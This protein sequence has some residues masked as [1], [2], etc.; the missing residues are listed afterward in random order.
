M[1]IKRPRVLLSGGLCKIVDEL[2]RDE[3]LRDFVL[4]YIPDVRQVVSMLPQIGEAYSLVFLSSDC[5]NTDQL[6]AGLSPFSFGEDRSFILLSMSVD[7]RE[8]L[9]SL[10]GNMSILT[11]VPKPLSAE[12]VACF[13]RVFVL[14]G[15][16][17][18]QH[19]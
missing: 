1:S 12:F 2:K 16:W 14:G 3:S 10:L 6:L 17:N 15:P 5:E 19:G 7:S 8:D 9:S 4:E 11:L 18:R 13:L